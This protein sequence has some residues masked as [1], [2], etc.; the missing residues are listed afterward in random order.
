VETQLERRKRPMTLDNVWRSQWRR[1]RYNKKT[2]RKVRALQD[3][4]KHQEASEL[5][6]EMNHELHMWSKHI[7]VLGT[8]KLR[9]K[10]ERYGVPLPKDHEGQQVWRETE[11]DSSLYLLPEAQFQLRKQIR[12]ERNER[13]DVW[14]NVVSKIGGFVLGI[15]SLLVALA[16]LKL[17]H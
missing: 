13:L 1:K 12:Q 3:Q 5:L 6:H 4:G 7:L 14:M 8:Q 15:L 16:A 10:A 11:D 9:I 17:K 2:L